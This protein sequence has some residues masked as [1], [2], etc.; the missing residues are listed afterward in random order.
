MIV[1]P[2][3]AHTHTKKKINQKYKSVGPVQNRIHFSHSSSHRLNAPQQSTRNWEQNCEVV[4]CAKRAWILAPEAPRPL[5]SLARKIKSTYLFEDICKLTKYLLRKALEC[6]NAAI[7][8]KSQLMDPSMHARNPAEFHF[9]EILC[10]R[11]LGLKKLSA[12]NQ[13]V[14]WRSDLL[15]AVF[16]YNGN[17]L[18]ANIWRTTYKAGN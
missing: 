1:S 9:P 12:E 3:T 10:P 5:N 16:C 7:Q 11:R 14:S 8:E 18:A 4:L 13:H 15:L 6:G 17:P 2:Q